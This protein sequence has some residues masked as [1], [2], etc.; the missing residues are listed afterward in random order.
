MKILMSVVAL[1]FSVLS[2][3]LLDAE[4]PSAIA[5][6]NAR[7]VPV[8]GP[9]I[10]KGTVLIRDGLIAGV[11]DNVA[12]PADAWVIDAQGLIVYPG[13]IDALSTWGIVPASIAPAVPVPAS[14]PVTGGRR[15]A[16]AN[17]E[18]VAHGPEER[19][20]THTWVRAADLLSPQDARVTS[21]RSAGFTSAVAFPTD[22]IF[23]GQGAVI[24]LAGDKRAMVLSTPAAQ[25]VSLTTGNGRSYPESLM[26]VIAY[27]RQVYLDAAH[28]Q[29]ERAAYEKDH[30]LRRPE[31]DRAVEGLVECPRTLLPAGNA[32]QLERMARFAAELKLNAILYGAQE[33]YRDGAKLREFGYPVLVSLK[34]PER[35]RDAD[36]DLRE[37]LHTLEV[38]E[39][40]PEGP[41]A[42]GKAGVRYAFYSDGLSGRETVRAVK[43]AIDAGLP[44][45]DALKAMTLSA[46]EIYGM[47][48]RLGSIEKG[49]IANL[50][51]TDG[52]LFQERTRVKFIFV[53]GRKYEP[54]P[55]PAPGERGGGERGSPGPETPSPANPPSAFGGVR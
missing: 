39:H 46:A 7:I 37:S 27:I 35:P 12:V 8:A 20:N 2:A 44:P 25:Y 54:V 33:A 31:Y 22:G 43:R 13:L 1:L 24:N 45:A 9:V 51:V 29:L 52:E 17:V 16:A 32:V 10:A 4:V 3:A 5:L 34:W 41:A 48:D 28:A 55:E 42:L 11:G 49:K 15:S 53:D 21:S 14:T 38:R 40:A 47:A 19:P 30:A 36:P 26:G 18:P 50:V 6:R 23:G